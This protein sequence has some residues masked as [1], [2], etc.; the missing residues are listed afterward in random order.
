MRRDFAALRTSKTVHEALASV[1][2]HPPDSRIIYFYVIDET[3]VLRGVVP[4]RRLLL[5]RPDALV[6]DILISQV[7]TLPA[8]ATVR[9]ACEGLLE[10]RL[11]ALPVVDDDG[12]LLGT[13]DMDLVADQL[14]RLDDFRPV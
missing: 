13:F 4:V 8:H 9:Q 14:G 6:A 5:G 2:Q 1:R 7:T 3:G 12:R 11:L 10:H